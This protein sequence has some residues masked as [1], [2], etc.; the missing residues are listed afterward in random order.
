MTHLSLRGPFAGP[1]APSLLPGLARPAAQQAGRRPPL[2][3][4]PLGRPAPASPPAPRGARRSG[5]DVLDED[6]LDDEIEEED[7]AELASFWRR[8]WATVVDSL[9]LQLVLA[10]AAVTVGGVAVEDLL[11]PVGG[12]GGRLA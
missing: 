8:V 9:L 12:G 5:I 10:V 3:S 11:G 1:A 7:V 6:D 2:P 4:P